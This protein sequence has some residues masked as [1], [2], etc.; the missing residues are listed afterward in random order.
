MGFLAPLFLLGGLLAA[1]PVVL[2]LTRRRREP[3]PFPSFLLLRASSATARW[4]RRRFRNLPLLILR[5][6]ALLLLAS[7]FARPLLPAGSVATGAALPLDLAVL[8]DRSLS[9]GVA[10]RMEEALGAA[11]EELER[12]G[13]SDRA[14]VVAFADRAAGL[15][16]LTGDPVVL[17][18]AVSQIAPG[19]GGT[20]FAPALGLSGRLLPAVPGRR[21]E[22]VLIS[23]L[24]GSGFED[25]RP[26]PSL[27]PGVA[28]RVRRVG[29]TPPVNAW[30]GEVR[31]APAGR[32]QLAV[33][34]ELRF[35]ASPA[36]PERDAEAALLISGRTVDRRPVR[37]SPDRAATVRFAVRRP[38]EPLVA[39]VRLPEDAL[40]G[41][42]RFRF[43]LPAEA[44]I[45]IGDLGG[46]AASVYVREAL[47]V[48]VSPAFLVEGIPAAA[49]EAAVR[50]ALSGGRV[51]LVRDPGRLGAGAVRALRG[52]VEAGGGLV[53][54]MGPRRVSGAAAS[55][56]SQLLPAA[57]GGF[58]DRSP[59]GRLADLSARHPVFEPFAG[60]AAS[61][62]GAAAFF[63]YRVLAEV[64]TEAETPARFDDGRPAI[65]AARRGEGRVLLFASSL[66]AEWN[67]LP[68]RPGFV[69]F[70][71]RLIE[72]AADYREIPI[73]HRVGESV[74]PGNAFR[75]PPSAG[76]AGEAAGEVL[77][78]T[79]SGVRTVLTGPAALHLGEAGFFRARRPGSPAGAP[80]FREIAVNPPLVES[81]LRPLD[82]EEVRIG[83]AARQEPE[84]GEEAEAGGVPPGMGFPLWWLLLG[85]FALLLVAEAWAAVAAVGR[86][87]IPGS[88]LPYTDA[89]ANRPAD[90][91]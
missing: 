90:S 77:V 13:R 15:T 18:E 10:G 12:L 20:R 58:V 86:Q 79:P 73:A 25:G 24:Q 62:L 37:L 42:D 44:A 43:L 6:L 29:G 84:A 71:H 27:P 59:P 35:A 55:A 49:G 50:R 87:T 46:G 76:E 80:V 7:A 65:V 63:R 19:T 22:V 61:A 9:M 21:R 30:I 32:D 2:H 82:A 47:G 75:L 41:D 66:D 28:L 16:G 40:P 39:E 14:I 11:G 52:F 78:E 68:R 91:R 53:M 31:V 1:L 48:G 34:A 89:G 23:D 69:P 60:E 17:R 54:A 45:R 70:L 3:V 88:L 33:T 67:D 57:P 56:L 38:T 5:G 8:L 74:D 64:S 36:V 51:A 72:V 85:G 83:A 81:D 4:K 26:R